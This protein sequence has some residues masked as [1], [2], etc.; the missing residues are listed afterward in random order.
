[1]SRLSKLFIDRRP[2]EFSRRPTPSY[3]RRSLAAVLM[4]LVAPVNA[5]QYRLEVGRGTEVCEAY[6]Q[7]LRNV[8][9]D[10]LAHWAMCLIPVDSA[11]PELRSPEWKG[12]G[13]EMIPTPPGV[14]VYKKIDAYIWERG[15]NPATF[16]TTKEWPLWRG[17]REQRAITESGG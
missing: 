12:R 15:V 16:V 13:S 7:N 6:E 4:L 2:G 14:N 9:P 11:I 1:M 5:D 17:T 10:P 8:P 3:V